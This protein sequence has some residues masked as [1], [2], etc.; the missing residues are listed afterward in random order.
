MIE[1]FPW[2]TAPPFLVR[3]NDGSYGQV[4]LTGS[5]QWEFGTARPHRDR[6]GKIHMWNGSSARSA[7]SASIMF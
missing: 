1:A 3:D 6:L 2:D 5:D 4:F 7:A